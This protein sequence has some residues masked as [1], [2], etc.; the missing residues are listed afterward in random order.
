MGG[1]TLDQPTTSLIR[2][3]VAV[4][5]GREPELRNAASALVEQGVP[6]VWVDELILQSVLMVGWPRALVAMG[7]WRS[8][9]DLSAPLQDEDAD[10]ALAEKWADRGEETCRAVYGVNYDKL[11]D[12]VRRLHP[13][14]DTWMVTEGYGRT[15]SR[16]GLDLI[17]RELCT[18]AQTA[19]LDTPHQFHSH[20]R[21][22]LNV[23]AT[24]AEIEATLQLLT[25]HLPRDQWNE[26]KRLWDP[27]RERDGTD[28]D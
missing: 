17:R 12:N 21:G 16:P 22:A 19:V 5:G 20:L 8:V 15:L 23:G 7:V 13:A 6:G 25:P 24:E 9:S 27:I 14:L 11:R 2:F 10:Y 26:M 1:A 28:A 3:A 4:A 18:V